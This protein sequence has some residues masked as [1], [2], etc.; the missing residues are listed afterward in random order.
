MIEL[1]REALG[2]KVREVWVVWAQEQPNPKPSWLVPWEDLPESDKEV[3][4]RIGVALAT[5]GVKLA[6]D[7]LKHFAKQISDAL[8]IEGC[9]ARTIQAGYETIQTLPTKVQEAVAA[10]CRTGPGGC[11]CGFHAGTVFDVAQGSQS[12]IHQQTVEDDGRFPEHV[13]HTFVPLAVVADYMAFW[14]VNCDKHLAVDAAVALELPQ[15]EA[16]PVIYMVDGDCPECGVA[17][18]QWENRPRLCEACQEKLQ[19]VQGS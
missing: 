3:D 11:W 10:A 14:C 9:K 15:G 12:A 18:K 19:D 17:V 8:A 5:E 7:R 13:G 1:D 6:D 4:R 2:Q 16:Y